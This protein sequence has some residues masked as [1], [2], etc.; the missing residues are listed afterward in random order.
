L[1]LSYSLGTSLRLTFYVNYNLLSNFFSS[2]FSVSDY[3][4]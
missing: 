4:L 3:G 2:S 1:C